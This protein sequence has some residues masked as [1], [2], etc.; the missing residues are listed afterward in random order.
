MTQHMHA[1]QRTLLHG[2]QGLS[3]ACQTYAINTLP[4]KPSAG[5]K[6][7]YFLMNSLSTYEEGIWP[8]IE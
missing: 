4:T 8:C 7:S 5:P 2:F 6:N 1:Y 3:S